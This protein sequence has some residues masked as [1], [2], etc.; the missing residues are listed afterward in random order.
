MPL[1]ACL[2]EPPSEQR[3]FD[4]LA[5]CVGDLLDHFGEN[6]EELKYSLDLAHDLRSR[7]LLSNRSS[8]G[9]GNTGRI[10]RWKA[11]RRLPSLNFFLP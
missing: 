6:N 10:A 4:W 8:G 9:H 1:I 7:E 11:I 5:S 3:V 2:D